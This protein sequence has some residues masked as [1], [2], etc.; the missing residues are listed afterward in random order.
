MINLDHETVLR[1]RK[2]V[3]GLVNAPKKWWDR[4]KTSL[5]KHG[6]TSCALNPCAFILQ[7]GGKIHG[8]LGV[9]IDVVIGGG[10]ETFDR[11][12]TTVRKEFD[13]GAWGV[14]NFR[15]RSRQISQMP[16]GEIVCD[17]EQ[18]KH[19]LE[20]IDVSKADTEEAL[21]VWACLWIIAVHSYHF[22]WQNCDENRRHRQ[23][24][25]Y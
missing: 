22:S 11:T 23:F 15:S 16:N 18:Y 7:K 19:E 17:M 10:N 13:F 2:A 8:V 24:K 12:M 5:I 14:G 3:Y 25:I 20:Q 4:L 1:L 9:H 6:F 21:G